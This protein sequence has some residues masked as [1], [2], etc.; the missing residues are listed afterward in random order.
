MNEIIIWNK[1]MAT[2]SSIRYN[3]GLSSSTTGGGSLKLISTQTASSDNTIQFTSGID[4]TY[5]KYIIKYI[6]VHPATDSQ[7]FRV[8]FRD[9]STDYDATVTSTA[10]NATADEADTDA[11]L[12]YQRARD[13]AQST[14]FQDLTA[15]NGNQNDSATSGEMFL[16]EPSSTTFVKHFFSRSQQM[17]VEAPYSTDDFRS[18]YCNTTSAIDGVQFKMS[19][20]N[21]DAGKIKMYGIK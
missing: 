3:M 6:D 5:K 18:G 19:S 15:F 2:Y 13:L 1:I 4:S 7:H 20:G 21:V 12:N 16:H 10:F 14:N 11:G 17:N 8:N 9:G